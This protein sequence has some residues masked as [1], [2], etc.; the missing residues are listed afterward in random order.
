MNSFFKSL[1]D[2]LKPA[3]LPA[4]IVLLAA[5]LLNRVSENLRSENVRNSEKL[6]EMQ[7][8][9]DAELRKILS[10]QAE[11]R[12]RHEENLKKLQEDLSNSLLKH[13]EKLKEIENIRAEESKKLLQKYK[14]DPAGL[15]LEMSKA[16]G[17][18][19]LSSP[20]R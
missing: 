5:F 1:Y 12:K 20:K 7:D 13:E 4:C 8:I 9:H 11:E 15:S 10:S 2:F 17:I 19:V 16:L 14:E 6:R 18:P 3:I